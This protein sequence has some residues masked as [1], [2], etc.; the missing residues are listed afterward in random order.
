M[1]LC[2]CCIILGLFGQTLSGNCFRAGPK[3]L[4]GRGLPPIRRQYKLQKLLMAPKSLLKILD[5][6]LV[7]C[8]LKPL[9][10]EIAIA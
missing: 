3:S 4:E 6:A 8:P 7:C 5:F 10:P 1:P 2:L 9:E